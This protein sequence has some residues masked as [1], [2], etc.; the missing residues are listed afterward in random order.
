MLLVKTRKGVSAIHGIGLF[1]DEF[2]LKGKEIWIFHPGFDQKWPLS[3]LKGLP[4][5]ARLQLLHYGYTNLAGDLVLCA[6]DARFFNH[7]K[8]PNTVDVAGSEEGI[9]VA[10]CDIFAGDEITCDYNRMGDF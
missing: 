9:T 4:E 5:A 6:D 7:S 3:A 8:I 10:A 2:I 1:A